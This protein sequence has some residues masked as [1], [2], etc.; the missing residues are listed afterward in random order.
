M[1]NRTVEAYLYQSS[2]AKNMDCSETNRQPL[3]RKVVGYLSPF[4]SQVNMGVHSPSN[5]KIPSKLTDLWL[6]KV[7]E[8]ARGHSAMD[9]ALALYTGG[10][11]S[12][13]DTTKV[14][15]TPILPGNPA[16]CTLSLTMPILTCSS[17]N[18]CHRGGKKR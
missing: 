15:S 6:S 10:W 14:Y 12:N 7:H 5:F 2:A 4:K 18:T 11:G 8:L 3:W 1:G 17:A 13:Q 9:K 16:T